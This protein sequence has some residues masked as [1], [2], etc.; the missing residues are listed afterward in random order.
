MRRCLVVLLLFLG[1]Q[2]SAWAD[3]RPAIHVYL[4]PQCECCKGWMAHMRHAGFLVNGEP[5]YDMVEVKQS[6]GIPQQ[7]QSCHSA[8]IGNYVIEGHVPPEDV[9]RL[10]RERPPIIGLAVP[11]MP[12]GSPGMEQGNAHEHFATYTIENGGV[13]HVFAEHN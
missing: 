4:N 2:V 13:T 3:D 8:V 10:L 12:V 7:L 6:L 5:V 11:G 9:I 1:L